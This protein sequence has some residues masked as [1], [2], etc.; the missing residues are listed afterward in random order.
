MKKL[1]LI[2]VSGLAI[3][4]IGILYQIVQV[5]FPNQAQDMPG[6]AEIMLVVGGVITAATLPFLWIHR[7]RK[8][9]RQ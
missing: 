9:L 4:A 3:I 1:V 7:K 2:L 6:F 5:M 8:P